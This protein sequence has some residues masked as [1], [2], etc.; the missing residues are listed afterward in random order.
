MV[1]RIKSCTAR[2]N[3][4]RASSGPPARLDKTEREN[5]HAHSKVGHPLLDDASPHDAERFPLLA[6]Q[7]PLLPRFPPRLLHIAFEEPALGKRRLFRHEFGDRERFGVDRRLGYESVRGGEAEDPGDKGGAAKEEKVPV[8]AGGAL[9][10]ETARLGHDG[11]DIVLCEG[12][13]SRESAQTHL[14]SPRL[15]NKHDNMHVERRRLTSK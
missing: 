8:E 12:E 14:Q 5:T 15:W 3:T 11:T 6:P 1:P 7:P 10:G 2:D 4:A 13:Y 9:D